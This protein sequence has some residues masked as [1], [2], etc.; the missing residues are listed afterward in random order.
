[1]SYIKIG[2]GNMDIGEFA[3]K[4]GISTDTLRYYDKIGL[5]VPERRCNRRNY[6]SDDM[7]K[8]MVIIKLKTIGF[9]LIEIMSLFK[10]E[11]GIDENAEL[12]D[13]DIK[14]INECLG[15][16]RKKYEEIVRQ[17]EEIKQTKSIIFKMIDKTTK[18]I[19]CRSF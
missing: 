13:S 6:C 14:N 10:L 12:N 2:G 4:T 7:D 9:T 1:M 15:I 11:E 19:E 5:L 17:E 8:A 18:L 16:I 3:F